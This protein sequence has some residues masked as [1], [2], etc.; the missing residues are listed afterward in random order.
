MVDGGNQFGHKS[1]TNWLIHQP[2]GPPRLPSLRTSNASVSPPGRLHVRNMTQHNAFTKCPL[3]DGNA[4]THRAFCQRPCRLR[5]LPEGALSLAYTQTG[6]ISHPP[7]QDS[8]PCVDRLGPPVFLF[9]M[10]AGCGSCVLERSRGWPRAHFGG[11]SF[12]AGFVRY[13]SM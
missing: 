7:A 6:R 9:E 3:S 12:S 5:F 1:L 10:P 8:P 11:C 13:G 2:S 4:S